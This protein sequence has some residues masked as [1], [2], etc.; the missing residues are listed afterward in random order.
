LLRHDQHFRTYELGFFIYGIA[1]MMLMPAIP[2]LFATYLDSDYAQFSQATVVTLQMTLMIMAPAVAYLSAGRRVTRVTAGA[3]ALL[4]LFPAALAVTAFTR[5]VTFA[6]VAFVIFG[7][8]MSG[9]RFVWN[10]GALAFAPPGKA[11]AYTSTH[12]AMVGMRAL[13]GFPLG[14]LMMRVF[15]DT[16]MPVFGTA[17]G[18]LLVA[19]VIVMRLDRRMNA[20]GLKPVV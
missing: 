10:L 15:D 4:A 9:V 18:L 14:Y 6:Y 8:A 3:F 17:A 5:D 12:A 7:L 19:T 20:A 16:L 2:V 11:L 1:F 13:I